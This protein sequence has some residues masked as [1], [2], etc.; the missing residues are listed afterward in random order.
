MEVF[1]LGHSNLSLDNLLERLR[2]HSIAVVLDV[3]SEPHSRYAPQFNAESL[4]HA[5]DAAGMEYRYEGK[6][7]GGKPADPALYGRRGVPDYFRIAA[8]P[9]FQDALTTVLE[10]AKTRRIVLLCSEADPQHCHREKLLARELRAR[11]MEVKHIL[12]DGALAAPPAQG[13]LL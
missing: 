3:R 11:G 1:T 12:A 2:Q 9:A 5:I 7:L 4:V 13:T 8:T 10:L 6:A